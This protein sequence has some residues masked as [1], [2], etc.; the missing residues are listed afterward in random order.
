MHENDG[1]VV[2]NFILQALRGDDITIYGDGTNTR[3]FQFVHDLVDGLMALMN[4]DAMGPIN[5]GNP[6]E[7]TMTQFAVLIK[8]LTKSTSKI[9]YLDATADDPK[10]RKPDI[11]RAKEQINWQPK[12]H[13]R[14]G[15]METI[16]Y[17]KERLDILGE[18]DY[19]HKK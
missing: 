17:F 10:K 11:T 3:S 6:E 14:Q 4:G 1:R 12:F 7:F 8:E 5:I 15:I 16:E 19:Q 2:S 9:V 18:G 13:V